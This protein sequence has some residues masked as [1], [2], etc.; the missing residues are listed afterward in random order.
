MER[1]DVDDLVEQGRQLVE[2]AHGRAPPDDPPV[3]LEVV[4]RARNDQE[5]HVNS[6]SG[7]PP[8]PPEGVPGWLRPH[9]GRCCAL[10][11]SWEVRP[12]RDPGECNRITEVLVALDE[13]R[14]GAEGLQAPSGEDHDAVTDVQCRESMRN[15][16]Q[17]DRSLQ[18]FE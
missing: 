15:D 17:R 6:S 9:G 2:L 14:R 1:G 13:I 18:L 4:G 8:S 11:L 7:G 10:A 12:V 5:A 16:Q 3:G